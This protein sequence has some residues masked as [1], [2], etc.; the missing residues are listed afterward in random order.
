MTRYTSAFAVPS[1]F[2]VST[3]TAAKGTT[4]AQEPSAKAAKAA[5]GA[6]GRAR[7]ASTTAT[8][9]RAA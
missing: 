1:G 4:S 2:A 7:Q 6:G 5:T 9:I 3:R 8:T